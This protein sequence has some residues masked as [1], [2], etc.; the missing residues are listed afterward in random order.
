MLF[1]KI[2]SAPLAVA[3]VETCCPVEQFLKK[4]CLSSTAYEVWYVNSVSL[5]QYIDLFWFKRPIYWSRVS[6]AI[7]KLDW[8]EQ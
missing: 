3:D 5:Y 8:A 6:T 1:D 2:L 4:K 7:L